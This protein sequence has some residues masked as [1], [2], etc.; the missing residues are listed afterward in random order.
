MKR[1]AFTMVEIIMTIVVMGILAGGTYVSLSKL[2]TKT[3]QTKAISELSFESTLIADQI[4]TL[5]SARV[6]ASV[7]GYD[8]TDESFTSIYTLNSTYTVLEWIGSDVMHYRAGLYSGFVDMDKSTRDTNTTYSPKTAIDTIL[9]DNPNT[10]LMF[11]GAYDSGSVLYDSNF[12]NMFGWHGNDH[13]A[14]YDLNASTTGNY[15]SLLSRPS[16]IYEKY[17]LLESA[18]AIARYSDIQQDATCIT[19]L[20]LTLTDN[21][22]LLFYDYYPWKGK[23]FCADPQG[24][25]AELNGSVTILSQ[26]ASGFEAEFVNENLQFNITLARDINKQGKDLKVQ[27]SKQKVV[28]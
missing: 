21:T 1:S 12:A 6:P 18:Y 25:G 10:A 28:F 22:L 5:L 26:E 17:Y 9:T 15:I 11:S 16:K 4:S 23:T 8:P 20:N 7:I 27:I 3:A 13:N 24:V 14:V 2:F 19:D